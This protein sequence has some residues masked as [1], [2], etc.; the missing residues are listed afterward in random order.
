MLELRQRLKIRDLRGGEFEIQQ[1]LDRLGQSSGENEV[2]I[3]RQTPHEQLE[4][5]AVIGLAG[6]EVARRHG[7]LVQ[8]RV[9]RRAQLGLVVLNRIAHY[10]FFPS[11]VSGGG[12]G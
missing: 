9:E 5:G 7:E 3:P 12:A 6:F 10:F 8:I 1:I 4:R 2:A 11:F